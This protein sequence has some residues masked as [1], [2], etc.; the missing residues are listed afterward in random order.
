MKGVICIK[1]NNDM[2]KVQSYM[3]TGNSRPQMVDVVAGTNVTNTTYMN[4]KLYCSYRRKLTVP[5]GSE[6]YMLDLTID[7]Y[8]MW[9][10]GPNASPGMIAKHNVIGK[11][12]EIT[13]IRFIFQVINKIILLYRK[14]RLP[15][16]N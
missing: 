7:R 6:D 13:D 9:A 16:H 15:Y 14:L 4:G 11:N 8:P 10:A 12:S 5:S 1:D 3:A 2:V